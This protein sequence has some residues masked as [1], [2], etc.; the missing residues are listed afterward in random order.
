MTSQPLD[1]WSDGDAYDAF[2]GRWSRPLAESFVRWLGAP[3][4]RHWLDVGTGTGALAAAICRLTSPASVVACDPAEAF[5]RLASDRLQDSRARFEVAGVGRLPARSGGYDLAV[6][7]LA[8]NFVP[9]PAEAVHEQLSLLRDGGRVAACV[10]DYARGMEFL[11]HFWDAVTSLD[12]EAAVHDEGNRFPICEPQAL[13]A[14]FESCGA[15]HVRTGE[16]RVPTVFQDFD[17]YWRPFVG[18][19]GPAPGYVATLSPDRY[20]DLLADLKGRLLRQADGRIELSARA[21][22][23]VGDRGGGVL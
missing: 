8:L 22:V 18:G 9:D 5:V 13:Q 16:L 12:P 14:L 21:W 10:W 4:G 2:M 23:V 17:D 19:P 7:A 3:D 20:D 6:S 11:R 1:A 15:R